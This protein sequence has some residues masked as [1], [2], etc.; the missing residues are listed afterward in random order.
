[1]GNTNTVQASASG[2]DFSR[3]LADRR[4]VQHQTRNGSTLTLEN[5]SDDAAFAKYRLENDDIHQ[6]VLAAAKKYPQYPA[7]LAPY[8]EAIQR[9]D[10]I[11]NAPSQT[12]QLRMAAVDVDTHATSANVAFGASG[13]PRQI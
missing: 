10:A 7:I 11:V 6:L 12:T 13:G 2:E 9:Y 4:E 5:Q 8:T 1:M 3:L